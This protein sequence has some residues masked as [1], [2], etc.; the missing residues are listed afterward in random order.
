MLLRESHNPDKFGGDSHRASRD[1]M[2]LI[3]QA[4]SQDHVI[5]VSGNIKDRKP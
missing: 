3:C 2:V 1:I 4:I 5:K